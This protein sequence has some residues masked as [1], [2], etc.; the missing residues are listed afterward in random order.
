VLSLVVTDLQSVQNV[1]MPPSPR[2]AAQAAR[3]TGPPRDNISNGTS[4]ASRS[5]TPTRAAA[6]SSRSARD[7]V[8]AQLTEEIVEHARTQL[9]DGGGGALSLRAIAREMGM[10]SSAIFRYFPNRDSLITTLVIDSY[11]ALADAAE[12]AEDR[13]H[14]EPALARWTAVCH[15]VRRWAIDHPHEYALIFGTPIPGYAAPQTTVT[16]AARVPFLLG[17]LLAELPPS[18]EPLPQRVTAAV[19]PI[20]E[21]LPPEVPPDAVVRG[22]M[23]WTYLFGAVSFEVFGHRRDAIAD[24]ESF[25][26]HEMRRVAELFTLP[27]TDA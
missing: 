26:D 5:A 14:G 10:A 15:A 24:P 1:P 3:K 18:G 12:N 27:A 6:S 9:A 17:R 7:R 16:P 25:F 2:H 20:R 4:T 22:L 8:R 11:T 13:A 23:A 21:S 19:A